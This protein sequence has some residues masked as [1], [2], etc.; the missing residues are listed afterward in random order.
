[1]WWSSCAVVRR[2]VQEAAHDDATVSILLSQTLLAEQEA[3][4]LE[5]KLAGKEQW[6]MTQIELLRGRCD[7]QDEVSRL[8]KGLLSWF[9]IKREVV[10]KKG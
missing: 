5:A 2:Q 9:M 3:K 4:E 6:L 7:L 10:K 1:M 8:E